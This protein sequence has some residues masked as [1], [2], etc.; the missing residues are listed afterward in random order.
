MFSSTRVRRLCPVLALALSAALAACAPISAGQPTLLSA[1]PSPSASP[2]PS[3]SATSSSASA[4]QSCTDP[5]ASLRPSGPLPAPGSFSDGSFM[6]VIH[7]RGKLIA[8]VSQDTLLFSYLNPFSNQLEGFD[9]EMARQVSYA[10]FGDETHVQFRVIT[11]AQRIPLLGSGA[12]DMV[13]S[14]FT[15]TCARWQQVD[16]SAVYY[17]SADRLLV[18]KTSHVESLQALG[19]KRVCSPTG[20]TALDRV[21]HASSHPI[22]VAVADRTDCLVL[23]QRGEVDAVANDESILLGLAAQDQSVKVVGPR[24]SDEPYGL[25]ASKAHPEFVRFLNAMLQNMESNGTWQSTYGRWL[26]S[27]GPAPSPPT[28]KYQS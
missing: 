8:G 18:P 5:T 2:A 20:S 23:L 10:I 22:P 19:R 4:T 11:P 7:D 24:F 13:A 14:T 12:I 3:P 16:F 6:Q 26:G 25:G 28:P 21:E 17:D 1:S 15:I 27:F 9:I